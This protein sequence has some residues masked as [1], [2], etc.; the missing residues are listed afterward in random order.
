M[1][2][3]PNPDDRLA[4]KGEGLKVYRAQ[5]RWAFTRSET[6]HKAPS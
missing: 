6:R 1:H 3:Q 2:N 5:R 4:P